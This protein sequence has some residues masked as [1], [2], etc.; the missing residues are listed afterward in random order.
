[1]NRLLGILLIA[2]I[3]WTLFDASMMTTLH[4][5]ATWRGITVAFNETP[6][7]YVEAALPASVLN[8]TRR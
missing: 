1:M 8:G 2:A 3:G 4:G 5:H 7:E 6:Q